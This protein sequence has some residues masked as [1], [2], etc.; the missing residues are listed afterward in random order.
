MPKWKYVYIL[1]STFLLVGLFSSEYAYASQTNRSEGNTHLVAAQKSSDQIP[2]DEEP[3]KGRPSDVGDDAEFDDEFDFPEDQEAVYPVQIADPLEPYNRVMFQINDKLYFWLLK[4]MAQGYNFVVAEDFRI[5]FSNFFSNVLTPL[6]LVNC[7]L[8]GKFKNAETEVLRFVVNSS[9]GILGFGD[10]GKQ[11][12]NMDISNEDFGQTLGV[13]GFGHGFYIV[14]PLVSSSSLRES[15]GFAV[16]L[17]ANPIAYLETSGATLGVG[18]Y[19]RFNDLSL[20]IGE[21]EAIKEAALEPY[22][23]VRNGYIQFRN[24]L[25]EK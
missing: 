8:Q 17:W 20:R 18:L 1:T 23:A 6:R 15:V 10:P 2:T 24:T 14:W 16:D 21:Y 3:S 9:I 13:W 12:F 5:C 22:S 19:R 25:V 7:L 11:M 4:P